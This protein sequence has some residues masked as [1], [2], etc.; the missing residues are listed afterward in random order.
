MAHLM[1]SFKTV[2]DALVEIVLSE[3][4]KVLTSY[5]QHELRQ[6]VKS[7]EGAMYS[8]WRAT[9]DAENEADILRRIDEAV[10][11]AREAS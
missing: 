7:I 9:M 1:T 10:A 5:Q 11:A 6:A 4:Y 3:D 8:R 2:S